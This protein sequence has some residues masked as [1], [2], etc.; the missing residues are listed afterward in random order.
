MDAYRIALRDTATSTEARWLD[1]NPTVTDLRWASR[2]PGLD[3][4]LDVGIGPDGGPPVYGSLRV[5]MG[6]DLL[7]HVELWRGA[8][9]LWVGR[10]MDRNFSGP[11]LS[12]LTCTGY[13]ATLSDESF[14]TRR[15]SYTDFPGGQLVLLLVQRFAP[16]VKANR[17]GFLELPGPPMS[18]PDGSR[19][20]L[21]SLASVLDEVCKLGS[22]G[23]PLDWIVDRDQ[24]LSLVER[25]PPSQPNYHVPSEEGWTTYGDSA[26]N[27][28]GRV[29]AGYFAGGNDEQETEESDEFLHRWKSQRATVIKAEAGLSAMEL[30]VI[31]A[32]HLSQTSTPE[33]R[34]SV[35]RR[36]GRG[37]ETPS[38]A[39]RPAWAADA[40][41]WFRIGDH[42]EEICVG[43]NH[44]ASS[45]EHRFELGAPLRSIV[46]VI[47]ETRRLGEAYRDGVNPTTS[48]QK[49]WTG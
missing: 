10:V 6:V 35:L 38:G 4:T 30:S 19:R 49:G 24:E 42:P 48:Q 14:I 5:P 3:T 12:S 11:Y 18:D 47:R 45:D 20:W 37:L 32:A 8:S 23:L 36:N 46:N 25:R 22:A 9:R 40:G 16:L 44:N 34:A 7:T 28:F 41:E 27:L 13:A 15:T 1:I 31:A 17:F 21:G 43:V 2:L 26:R 29:T 39:E 33:V